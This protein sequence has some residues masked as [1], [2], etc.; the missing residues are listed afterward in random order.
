MKSSLNRIIILCFIFAILFGQKGFALD[1]MQHARLSITERQIALD[2]LSSEVVKKQFFDLNNSKQLQYKNLLEKGVTQNL[3]K[4]SQLDFIAAQA[5]VEGTNIALTDAT[6][7]LDIT[8]DIIH[9]LEKHLQ[10]LILLSRSSQNYG[11]DKII[12]IEAD[13]EILRKLAQMQNNR[14]QLLNEIKLFTEKRLSLEKNWQTKI[15]VLYLNQQQQLQ[16]NQLAK[17]M[18][19]L[20]QEQQVWLEK[21]SSLNQQFQL[22]SQSGFATDSNLHKLQLRILEAEENVALL[23]LKTYLLHLQNRI[24]GFQVF[25]KSNYSSTMVN[26][27]VEQ[28]KNLLTQI[29]ATSAFVN[30]KINFLSLKK[31]ELTNDLSKQIMSYPDVTI[32]SS[33]LSDLINNFQKQSVYINDL[34]LKTSSYEKLFKM[35]LQKHLSERQKLPADLNGWRNLGQKLMQ[36]PKLLLNS[37]NNF[38]QQTLTELNRFGPDIYYFFFA[39]VVFLFAFWWYVKRYIKSLEINILERRQRFSTN[40]VYILLEIVRRNI[41]GAIL[42]FS[43]L[44]L[45]FALAVSSGLF[46]GLL[47]VYTGYRIILTVAKIVLLENIK[48]ISGKDVSLYYRIEWTFLFG[49]LFTA[50]I[51][52]IHELP[53]AYDAKIFINRLFMLFILLVGILLLRAKTVLPTLIETVMHVRKRYVFRILRLLSILVPLSLIFN[54]IVGLTGYLEL[55]WSIA[56]FQ[57]LFV[58]ILVGYLVCRGLLIDCL[59][60]ISEVFIRNIKQGWLWTEAFLKPLDAVVRATLF[61]LSAFFLIHSFGLDHNS[62]FINSVNSFLKQRIFSIGGNIITPVIL[63]EFVGIILLIKWLARW[64]REFSYRWFY[65]KAK[66]VGVRNS[67]SVFTQYAS[68][69]IAV[70]VA[71]KCLGIDLRGFTVVAAAFAAGIG[72]GMRDLI[73]NFISGILLLIERPFRAGDIITLGN[74]EG[75]VMHTGMRSMTIRTWDHMDVIVPNAD[76]FTKPFVN[77]THQDNIVRSVINLK[78]NRADDPHRVQELILALLNK[79]PQVVRDPIPEVIMHEMSESLIEMQVRYYIALT[80]QCSRVII[81]SQVLFAIWDCFKS[82]DI[83]SPNPQFDLVLRNQEKLGEF[84]FSRMAEEGV[85]K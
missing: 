78:I 43:L 16:R 21:L 52:V 44:V 17:S 61:F 23:R 83:R 7:A 49:G 51:L 8:E 80:P 50:L 31:A 33:M 69:I 64:S 72:F 45:K 60:F 65:A 82:N 6:Q 67:L 55:A 81:R 1:D 25:S 47:L 2:R 18:S 41:G 35:Q 40:M 12:S 9:N 77:W 11:E 84:S 68:V 57:M 56:R 10:S 59:E 37:L 20:Q 70:L 79:H 85:T 24:Q 14:I 26:E 75:E 58:V 34:R 54:G 3:I 22:L 63:L 76:M 5:A 13:L 46:V 73:I 42:I 39:A 36:I 29:N 32:Y 71:M 30:A 4:H 48:D 15:N 74:H 19:S 53:V 27:L 62:Q 66:D 28:T 38:F